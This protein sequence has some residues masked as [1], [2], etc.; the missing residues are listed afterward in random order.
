MKFLPRSR[1]RDAIL[2]AFLAV[3]TSGAEVLVDRQP[4]L[5]TRDVAE[6]VSGA[7]TL[8]RYA[9]GRKFNSTTATFAMLVSSSALYCRILEFDQHN[10]F[11]TVVALTRGLAYSARQLASKPGNP[12]SKLTS[13]AIANLE[14]GSLPTKLPSRIIPEVIA[15]VGAIYIDPP[16]Q[17]GEGYAICGYHPES[18][19]RAAGIKS[20]IL[21]AY[22]YRNDASDSIQVDF[23]ITSMTVQPPPRENSPEAFLCARLKI[24]NHKKHGFPS[25]VEYFA[26][27]EGASAPDRNRLLTSA[28]TITQE[29]RVA[30]DLSGFQARLPA[31]DESVPVILNDYTAPMP[32]TRPLPSSS[33]VYVL[34]QAITIVDKP[35]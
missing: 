5:E 12:P 14:L 34:P 32:I 2:A 10:D 35:Y 23:W 4:Q 6:S 28:I 33:R 26:Y 8:T 18:L 17:H 11:K 13:L 29:E 7:I 27:S 16:K 20:R 25:R 19:T 31:Y 30:A 1:L 9:Q 3:S 24:S 15:L 22:Y 21:S